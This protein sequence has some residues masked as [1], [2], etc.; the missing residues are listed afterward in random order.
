A[1][2]SLAAHA[3]GKFWALHDL[4][5]QNQRDLERASLDRYAA[6]AGLDLGK[7]KKAL[8]EHTYSPAGKSDVK[9]GTEAHVSGTPSMFIGTERVENATDFES[10]SHAIDRRL[11]ID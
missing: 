2:A 8:D 9:L 4:L 6:Q 3:Q 10:L 11:A 5:F 1:E 7:V